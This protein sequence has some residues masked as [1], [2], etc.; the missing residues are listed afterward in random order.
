[1]NGVMLSVENY[2]N[3][4]ANQNFLKLQ[5]AWNESEEQIAASRRAYNAAVTEYNDAFEMFPGNLLAG[6]MSFQAKKV[7]EITEPERQNVSA[8]DL[9]A[10]K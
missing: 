8:K 5:A 1:M 7:F 10:G 2:P 6:M 9:F 4:K 3:L